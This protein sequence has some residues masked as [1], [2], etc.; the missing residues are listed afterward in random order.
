MEL[1][2]G[3]TDLDGDSADA[4]PLGEPVP[5]QVPGVGVLLARKPRPR[6]LATLARAYDDDTKPPERNRWL[7]QFLTDHTDRLDFE[8]VLSAVADETLPADSVERVFRA[9]VTWGTQRPFRAVLGL[10][11]TAG[12]AWRTIRVQIPTDPMAWPSMHRVLDEVE[13][14]VIDSQAT[15][16]PEKDRQAREGYVRRLYAA[17]QPARG[18][19]VQRAEPPSW[20]PADGGAAANSAAAKALAAAR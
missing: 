9:I 1:P 5:L 20:W 15:G 2:A 3:F 17:E 18:A 11:V 8:R 19:A 12:A 16:D 7:N 13:R 6:S 14:I 4:P 10:A